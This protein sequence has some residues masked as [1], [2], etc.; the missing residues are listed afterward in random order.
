MCLYNVIELLQNWNSLCLKVKKNCIHYQ[1]KNEW[2]REEKEWLIKHQACLLLM[3]ESFCVVCL[4]G[5][6][7]FISTVH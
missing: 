1:E 4:T 2:G 3:Q 5:P 7:S 6:Q